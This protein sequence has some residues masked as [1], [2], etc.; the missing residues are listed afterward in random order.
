MPYCMQLGRTERGCLPESP[1]EHMGEHARVDLNAELHDREV[2]RARYHWPMP[3]RRSQGDAERRFALTI[4][5]TVREARRSARLTQEQ[6]GDRC[7]LSQSQIS[8]LEAGK[9]ESVT[10]AE[11]A[12]VLDALGIRADLA[13]RRPFVAEVPFQHDAAHARTLAYVVRR[14]IGMG[15]QV[16]VEVEIADPRSPG[17]IDLLGHHP[18]HRALFIAEIKAGLQDLGAAQRQLAWY[19]RVAV[20]L[21]RSLGWEVRRLANAMLVLGTEANDELLRRNSGLV[22][23]A[24][25]TR[26]G[27][28][29]DWLSSADRRIDGS[30]IALIDPRS[31]RRQ[32]LLPTSLDGRRSSLRYAT[33]ADFMRRDRRQP[34][35][36]VRLP[37]AL[38]RR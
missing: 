17:W 34:A 10:L 19:V 8:R 16:R 15:W 28:M 5:T 7:G 4:P 26:A 32:W 1:P 13:L 2:R 35:T 20:P 11:A 29:F 37:R 38:P 18:S 22:R 24:F 25:P 6:L 30:G 23:Q 21:A 33:Y 3:V 9:I 31:R 27:G 36:A 14:L 12:R